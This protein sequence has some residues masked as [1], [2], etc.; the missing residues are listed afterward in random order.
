MLP[1]VISGWPF[2][3]AV[4]AGERREGWRA[5]AT[6]AGGEVLAPGEKEEHTRTEREA[7][8]IPISD[9]TWGAIVK[10]AAGVGVGAGGE[11]LPHAV[12]LRD[13]HRP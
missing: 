1:T 5:Q 11:E 10:A 2:R 12:G 4:T 9:E 13:H 7:N 3:T 8:G 6:D